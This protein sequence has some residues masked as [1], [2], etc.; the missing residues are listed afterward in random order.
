MKLEKTTKI[1]V[2]TITA[3]II[4]LSAQAQN[5]S[6]YNNG[7]TDLGAYNIMTNGQILGQ[8]I[9][10]DNV[11][12]STHPYLQDFS[13]EYYSLNTFLMNSV[14]VDVKFY[15]NTGAPFNGYA[16]PGA[17]PFY[18]SGW[19]GLVAPQDVA[20]GGSGLFVQKWTLVWQDLYGGQP[21][22]NDPV[23]TV[24]VT[25][26]NTQVQLP[27]SFTVIYSFSNT[28]GSLDN[29]GLEMFNPPAVGTNYGDYWVNNS[30]SWILVTNSAPYNVSG[31][32]MDMNAAA[33]PAPEPSVIAMGM[34]GGLLM[35]HLI[36]RRRV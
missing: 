30:G 23:P 34:V 16:T 14:V 1:F 20:N 19:F 7:G 26:M 32:G 17:S 13:F 36:R 4:V 10:L 12:L 27:N 8:E 5:V 3:A 11:P 25:A 9:I 24:P 28:L 2:W 33:T 22:V 31:I 18:D 15:N 35:T 6:V 21:D 29:F